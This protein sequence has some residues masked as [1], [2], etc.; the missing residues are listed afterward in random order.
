[1]AD[2]AIDVE[3]AYG[4]TAIDGLRSDPALLQMDDIELAT[5]GLGRAQL[6]KDHLRDVHRPWLVGQFLQPLGNPAKVVRVNEQVDLG[7]I[8]S[9]Q[10]GRRQ[11]HLSITHNVK[12][13][14]A[15][16]GTGARNLVR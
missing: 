5:H 10:R 4:A 11:G 15:D 14:Q 3:A 6:L 1:V 2:E 13:L 9:G 16:S 8:G 7:T 12:A